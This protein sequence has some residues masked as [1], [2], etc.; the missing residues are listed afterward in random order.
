[1]AALASA[2]VLM[3]PQEAQAGGFPCICPFNYDPV[4]CDGG[5]TYG[6]QCIAN[7]FEA[8]GCERV[9]PPTW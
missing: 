3:S 6:N 4:V 5:A 1:M 2:A 8:T 7:C 9:G